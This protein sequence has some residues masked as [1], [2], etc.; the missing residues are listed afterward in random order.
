[1]FQN[2]FKSTCPNFPNVI[3]LKILVRC[4]RFLFRGP[5]PGG[6][7]TLYYHGRKAKIDGLILGFFFVFVFV[8][9]S[10]INLLFFVQVVMGQL[11]AGQV[12][13]F[14]GS[15]DPCAVMHLIRGSQMPGTATD[16]AVERYVA[17]IS[18][19]VQNTLGIHKSR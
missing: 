12:F 5:Y 1:M 7:F 9:R 18:E 19:H 17:A 6:K 10:E 13:D 2:I 4:H 8:D 11:R 15:T 16:E 14:S 3:F